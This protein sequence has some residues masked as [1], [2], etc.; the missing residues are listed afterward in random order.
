MTITTSEQTL[1]NRNSR[2]L[3]RPK[4]RAFIRMSCLSAVLLSP[5]LTVPAHADTAT[6]LSHFE[7][8]QF[9]EAQADWRAAALAGDA[10]AA[11]FVGVTYDVGEGVPRSGPE[12]AAWYARA[13]SLGSVTAMF[14]LGVLYDAG[15][16]VARDSNTAVLWYDRAADRRY[17]RAEY[18]LGLIYE[19][20]VGVPKDRSRAIHWFTQAAADGVDAARSHLTRLGKTTASSGGR[21]TGPKQA[22]DPGMRAFQ[23]A[24]AVFL[25]RSTDATQEA[26]TLFKRSAE[27]NNPL[28][29]YDLGYCYEHSIGVPEDMRQAYQWYQQAVHTAADDA[30][31]Q[32]A[33]NS[34]EKVAREL[35]SA[36]LR[37]ATN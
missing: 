15:S 5:A 11:L 14:N 37:D 12:A 6:G 26:V 18:N 25:G 22:A 27:Q 28:A 3:S 8:G 23:N 30:L 35:G 33:S 10:D 7:N 17:A 32:M 24:E 16:G 9:A 1:G 2:A 20:G 19:D 21:A 13:A 34:A 4:L 29:A 36:N 31:R